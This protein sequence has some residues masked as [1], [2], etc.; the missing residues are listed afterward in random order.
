MLEPVTDP[1]L[2]IDEGSAHVHEGG[3]L[4]STSVVS[5]AMWTQLAGSAHVLRETFR[6]QAIEHAFLEPRLP[7]PCPRT[8]ASTCTRRA[9]AWDDR[10]QI[11][12]FL[13]LP[14]PRS[15]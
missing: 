9:R 8:T 2:A 13:G 12:S 4:L 7:S 3:N 6:T 11:A 15:G 14:E 10:R 1:L 5:A